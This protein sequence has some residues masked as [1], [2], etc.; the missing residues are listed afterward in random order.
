MFVAAL[1]TTDTGGIYPAYHWVAKLTRDP[2][3]K[4]TV[5]ELENHNFFMRKSSINGSFSIAIFFLEGSHG[6]LSTH[7]KM[8]SKQELRKSPSLAT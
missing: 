7:C 3:G 6:L 1:V 8:H 5:C 2:S 4:L